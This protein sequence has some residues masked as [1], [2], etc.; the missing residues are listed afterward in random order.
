[1]LSPGE[2]YKRVPKDR[3]ANL[4]Y[5]K[6]LNAECLKSRAIREDIKAVCA[7]D[8]LF[9]INSFV[10]QFNP[11][12]KG[13]DAVGPFVTWDFQ[14]RAILDRPETTGRK[15]VL[16][17][18]EN[19]KSAVVEKSREMGASWLFLIFQDWLA[20]F[21][22]YFQ[23]L[24]ISRS[25]AAVDDKSPDSLFWKIGFM[26]E[27]LPDWLMG[28]VTDEHLYLGYHETKSVITGEA[29]TGRAGVGG[30]AG[31]I[32]IDEFPQIKQDVEVRQRTANTADCR[33]FNG[34]HLGI[35]TEFYN[36]TKSPEF[37]KIQMHWTR[38][39]EKNKGLYSWDVQNNRPRFYQY[40]PVTDLIEELPGPNF[41]YPTDFQFDTSGL[42][43][44]GPHPGI[45]SPWYDWK[46]AEVGDARAV[47]MEL[48]IDPLG[49]AKQFFDPVQIHELKLKHCCD[50]VWV[51]DLDY[52]PEKAEP[53]R[54]IEA[55]G[56]PIRMW[57]RPDGNGLP[58]KSQYAFGADCAQGTGATPTCLSVANERGQKV[59]EFSDAH[60]ESHEFAPFMIALARLFKDDEGR[61]ALVC[62]EAAGP[63]LSVGIKVIELGYPRLYYKVDDFV[64]PKKGAF[65]KKMKAD[66]PG[67]YPSPKSKP[68]LLKQYRNALYS[69]EFVNRSSDALEQ[70]LMF[71]YGPRGN[72][73]HGHE[74][75][76][77]DPS[78]ARDNHADMVIAD[79]LACKMVR[80]NF[81][82]ELAQ[83]Q[84]EVQPN[85][86]GWR[87]KR[88][89]DE[90]R[91]KANSV[92]EE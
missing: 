54:L 79:A 6:R 27:H 14:E 42:P 32:F 59:L 90:R 25:E 72:I 43:T 10:W 55:P 67:W 39:P 13:R 63:G 12:K 88:A 65:R 24:N 30:R 80:E 21:H 78:G 5:R 81:V 19:N 36:L 73:I 1:M 92:W 40:D 68:V 51:G 29:S 48:D 31:V 50:P 4:A 74:E 35:G 41:E 58:P 49:A 18:Y 62:W 75:N 15:G 60:M 84:L 8:I 22:P 16:W 45:R 82:V 89:E 91:A 28:K 2:W 44:G 38:H 47:A 61:T 77:Q 9:Y 20:A 85:T 70:C 64:D 26:H 71:E 76:T 37:V 46:A 3:A 23:A 7:Q 52:D 69:R 17:C 83:A 11:K 33:F 34:T 57:V 53:R 87:H 86:L 56:G 66:R